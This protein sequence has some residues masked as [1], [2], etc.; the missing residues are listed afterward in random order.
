MKSVRCPP[1]LVKLFIHSPLSSLSASYLSSS[2]SSSFLYVEI[3]MSRASLTFM[4]SWYSLSCRAMSCLALCRASSRSLIRS[5]ASCTAL[6]PRFSAS[7]I[8]LS[9]VEHW[10]GRRK[11]RCKYSVQMMSDVRKLEFKFMACDV[12]VALLLL[13]LSACFGFFVFVFASQRL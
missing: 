4:S 5:L 1:S 2:P 13:S 6:S 10:E 11:A 9:M 8:W 12:S 3:S 7:F